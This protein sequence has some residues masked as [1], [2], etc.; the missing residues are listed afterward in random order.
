MRFWAKSSNKLAWLTKG[1]DHE[2]FFYRVGV[3]CCR[4]RNDHH[5][6][7]VSDAPQSSIWALAF[8]FNR[9]SGVLH[10]GRG[11]G[12]QRAME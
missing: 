12:G 2:G 11:P 1:N 10:R 8:P 3:C 4:G 7:A 9:W 5:G 6:P